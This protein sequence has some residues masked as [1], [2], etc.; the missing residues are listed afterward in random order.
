MKKFIL[1]TF[2]LVL[3]FVLLGSVIYVVGGG[4]ILESLSSFSLEGFILILSLTF[5]GMFIASARWYFILKT[6]GVHVPFWKLVPIW[7][8]ANSFSYVTPIVYVGGEGIK[9]YFLRDR[10]G[11][12]LSKSTA[13]L[14]IEKILEGTAVFFLLIGGVV[15]FLF[16]RQNISG[17]GT[18]LFVAV[19]IVIVLAIFTAILYIQSFRNKKII[20]PIAKFFSFHDTRAGLLLAEIEMEMIGFLDLRSRA[21]WYALGLSFLRHIGYW[22]RNLLLI[23]YLG[24]GLRIA[25]SLS[26]LSGVYISYMFP[27][28]GAI[29]AQEAS[30]SII[31][32]QLGWGANMGAA[33]SFILRAADVILIATGAFFLFRFSMDL[34][35]SKLA[36][37][38]SIRKH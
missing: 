7:L 13:L 35:A 31:F 26:T 29:G 12:P 17:L 1:G 10:F 4:M 5:L 3:G 30:Q 6:R 22:G 27:I 11:V 32:S 21:M 24:H 8:A 34:L 28:P 14:V 2:F 19:F 16:Y 36:G 15:A 25:A 9:V 38:I 20:T 33:F 37:K 18:S 23:Y